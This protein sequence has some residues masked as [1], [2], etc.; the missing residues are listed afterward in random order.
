M[1]KTILL[2]L[3]PVFAF[4]QQIADRSPFSET[5][6]IWNPAMTAVWDYWEFSIN[7]RQ[8]WVGFNDAPRTISIGMQY[9]FVDNNMSMGGFVV[10]DKIRPLQSNTFGF[11]YTYKFGLGI[12][13]NDQLSLGIL[14]SLN[15]YLFNA[16]DFEIKDLDDNLVPIGESAKFTPNV[17]FGFFY[18]TYGKDAY[19]K[20]FFFLGAAANQI[21]QGSLIF[22][23]TSGDGNFKRVLH[24]NALLGARFINDGVYIQPSVW[25]N[26]AYQNLVDINLNI[27]MEVPDSFWA[28][29]NYSTNQT[30]ALQL[31]YIVSD[32]FAKDGTMRIGVLGSYNIGSFGQ[33]RGLGYEFY[34]AYRFEV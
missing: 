4:G 25:V 1:R 17:G 16:T 32:G 12:S 30:V 26:Y 6:F 22:E 29:L 7:Y 23:Q 8:Q 2:L 10:N 5:S 18:T 20:N 34:V 27:K 3:F 21:L 13:D 28:G 14:A 9:P 31:G 11:T 15:H 19:R 33:F 24:G